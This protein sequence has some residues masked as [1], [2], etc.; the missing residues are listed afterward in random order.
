MTSQ[1]SLHDFF[2]FLKNAPTA[3]HAAAEIG[4]RCAQQDFTPLDEKE[5]WDLRPGGCYFTVRG[6]A[7][8]AFTL[9]T[10]SLKK[11]TILASHTDSPALKVKPNPFFHSDGLTF[12]RTE[13]YGSPILSTYLSRDLVLAGRLLLETKE[14]IKETL[15]CLDDTPFIIPSLAIHLDQK[16]KP[17]SKQDH[18][19]PLVGMKECT[20]ETVT[21]H[22]NILG[23]DLFLVPCDAPR[24]VGAD[25]DLIAAYRL[26]NLSSAHASLLA[27]L[28]A[29]KQKETLQMALFWNHEEIGSGTDEGA[30]SPFLE[31]TLR[32]ISLHFK[33]DEEA[34]FCF[35]KSSELI[36]IDMAHAF[37]PQY[38]DRYDK[39]HAPKLG[40]GVVIKHHGNK[41][42]ATDGMTAAHITHVL[43][44]H[45]LPIQNFA[46]H[47]DL[48]CGS[49]VGS[50]SATRTGIP[51]VDIGIPQLA[52]H[53]AREVIS[54]DD[55]RT[56]SLALKSLLE[57]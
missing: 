36:S 50:L 48:P 46:S 11:G 44:G 55:Q 47:S 51:T 45:S 30:S 7:V 34:F 3:W 2:C 31:E 26:D 27:L 1:K 43:K 19:C 33:Q 17:I 57:A 16:D 4:M 15:I 35:K 23:F 5:P 42:Y 40:K 28:A 25:Q 21:N 49:T 8:C 14:G 12:L 29:K 41:R 10:T 37:H 52:M 38:A 22:Q 18:L 6:G 9:P 39:A 20:L 13:T 32:R 24:F 56:L 53:S 54:I